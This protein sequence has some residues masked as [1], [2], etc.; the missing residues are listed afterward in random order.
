MAR[1][2][3][4]KGNTASNNTAEVDLSRVDVIAYSSVAD[5]AGG[6]LFRESSGNN[7]LTTV[8][9][10]DAFNNQDGLSR[11]NRFRYDTPTFWGFHLAGA[12]VSDQRYDASLWWSGQGYGFK[13]GGGGGDCQ[14]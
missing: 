6:M 12:A 13:G 1:L 2:W 11:Q 8:S 5:I 9:V 4:G 7:S 3:L 10:A 14:S